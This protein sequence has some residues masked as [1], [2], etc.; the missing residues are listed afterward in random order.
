MGSNRLVAREIPSHVEITTTTGSDSYGI[1]CVT[2][3]PCDGIETPIVG[4]IA[5]DTGNA[6][7]YIATVSRESPAGV[8]IAAAIG[9]RCDRSNPTVKSRSGRE[10]GIEGSIVVDSSDTISRCAAVIGEIAAR[11]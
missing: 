1:N 10:S 8:D 3:K 11:I 7:S 2:I 4:A 9:C 5:E 6:I